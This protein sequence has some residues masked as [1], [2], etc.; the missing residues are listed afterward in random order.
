MHKLGY[1]LDREVGHIEVVDPFEVRKGVMDVSIFTLGSLEEVRSKD[2]WGK[3]VEPRGLP[4]GS[5]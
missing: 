2:S 1:V 5:F 4:E 3:A